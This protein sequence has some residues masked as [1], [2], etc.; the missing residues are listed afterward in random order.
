MLRQ[1]HIANLA[2]IADVT[3]DLGPGL[4][5]F[6]GQTG[7]GKSL[8]IG[9]FEMLL[10]LRK[11]TADH[12]RP[13]T[14]QARISGTFDPSDAIRAQLAGLFDLT[15]EP[16]D[17]LLLTRKL[18]RTGRS[19]FAVNAQPVTAAMLAKAAELLVD[20]HGQHDHQLLLKPARQLALLDAFGNLQDLRSQ[21]ADLHHRLRDMHRTRDELETS[22]TLRAQQ[23]DLFEFQAGEIDDAEPTDGEFPELQARATMF[24]SV[25]RLKT[26]AA[27]CYAALYDADGSVV[28]RL[29][30]I[31][32]ALIEVAHLDPNAAD[33]TE[34]VRTATLTL[35]E[36]A[37]EL[38]RYEQR[39]DHD[40]QEAAEVE[41][42]LNTLNRL[43]SKYAKH[44]PRTGRLGD[45]SENQQST[46]DPLEPVLRY[47]RHLAEQIDA[48]RAKTQDADG[49]EQRI[50][51]AQRDLAKL[52][53][54]L[55][56]HRKAAAQKLLPQV[57]QHLRELG[58]ADA[59]LEAAF[60]PTPDS[61]AGPATVELLARTNLGQP[62]QPLRAI[63]SGGE[64]SRVMLALKSVKQAD[65]NISVLVFDEVD[66]NI[67]GRLGSAIG[68]KLRGLASPPSG[69][70]VLCITHL[71][72]IAAFGHQHFRIAKASQG[73]GKSAT[74][75]TIVEHLEGKA[76]IDELAEMLAGQKVTPT[77]KKQ[78]R[79][80]LAAAQ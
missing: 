44:I 3:L 57:E 36:A 26:D 23:L 31:T 11:A 1:L 70:Q 76:R 19:S 48:L 71:P 7:A 32:A 50:A 65:A 29:Q 42:R 37:Y 25:E 61:P 52:G 39:L 77:T 8:I 79:E 78:A 2:V 66:A 28:E 59:R 22:R 53:D 60:A 41:S 62:A 15:L 68:Q 43:I 47:R 46:T 38:S 4:N 17:E 24:N 45:Q 69:G 12:I 10:G 75:T 14:D 21:Y 30:Q 16:G 20:I 54:D 49:L 33:L 55:T 58:M 74:T 35:Q 56:A 5:V 80:L 27:A 9:A 63:A 64:L 40:P 67:G 73:Q 13:G 51:A 34:Q 18:F 6:T 72:Q